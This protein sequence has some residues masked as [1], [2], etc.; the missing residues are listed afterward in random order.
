MDTPPIPATVPSRGDCAG[1]R[2]ALLGRWREGFP[3]QH[4]PYHEL[5]RLTGGTVRELLRHCRSLADDGALHG[6][7]V[8]WGD[9]LQRVVWRVALT[10]PADGD[11][12]WV[13]RVA[14]TPGVVAIDRP[15]AH[16]GGVVTGEAWFTLIARHAATARAQ[17]DAL[18]AATGLALRPL[19]QAASAVG[20]EAVPAA[21]APCPC[22]HPELARLLEQRLPLSAH[23]YEDLAARLDRPERDVLVLLRRWQRDGRLKGVGLQPAHHDHRVPCQLLRAPGADVAEADR[24]EARRLPGV[25]DAWRLDGEVQ[26]VV[27][28]VADG[29]AAPL[30]RLLRTLRLPPVAV[31]RQAVMRRVVRAQPLLFATPAADARCG[32]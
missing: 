32:G 16:G 23:P 13:D 22:H 19:A 29:P 31:R 18:Q 6:L 20:G 21:A 28:G 10:P 12:R 27:T 26:C 2:Q 1:L 8:V 5:A 15:T 11:D 9:A 14:A 17:L 25:L 7:Q 24:A 3:L 4:S 30:A